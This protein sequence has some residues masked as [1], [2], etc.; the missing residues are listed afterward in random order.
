MAV[1]A[2]ALY[3]VW[4][5]FAF[6]WKTID[7]RRRTG[8]SGLRLHA[9]RNTPQWWAKLGFG[10]A[11]LVGLA[12]PVAAV[13]GL[14]NLPPL[15]APW[16]HVAGIALAVTGIVLTV[17]AQYS[18]GN[19]WRIGVDPNERTGLVTD[20]AFRVV[21]NP[22]FSAMAITA[23]GLAMIIPNLVSIIGLAS[24]IAALE[25]QVR[26]VEEPYLLRTHP[27]QYRTYARSVGRFTPGIGYI[28]L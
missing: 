12:A 7:Q 20:G 6:G 8:D 28:D 25:I 21:R 9:E 19:S 13:A 22:V 27:D 16:L 17:A 10:I 4:A 5:W 3:L 15:D 23:A 11:I 24:L 26:L 2:L 18:M 14:D 1:T